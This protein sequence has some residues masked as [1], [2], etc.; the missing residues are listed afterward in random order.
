MSVSV[1]TSDEGNA[2]AI[3]AFAFGLI[4]F[5]PLVERIVVTSD[6]EGVPLDNVFGILDLTIGLP[7]YIRATSSMGLESAVVPLDV[8]HLYAMDVS[9]ESF[10][11]AFGSS[12]DLRMA[13]VPEL[14]TLMLL[15]SGL[16]GV[17]LLSKAAERGS[18]HRA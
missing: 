14:S 7:V 4:T 6:P 5:A 15:L 16:V 1:F 11:S 9:V 13:P 2:V 10:A 12:S 18:A 17:G 3:H 8:S